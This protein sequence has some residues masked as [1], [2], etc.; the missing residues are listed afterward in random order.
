MASKGW[1]I[2]GKL[3]GVVGALSA[4]ISLVQYFSSSGPELKATC[5]AQEF[6]VPVYLASY[7]TYLEAQ[8][9][10]YKTYGPA[11]DIAK[12]FLTEPTPSTA[13]AARNVLAELQ[14]PERDYSQNGAFA[15]VA[16]IVSCN[17]RN[18]GTKAAK[19]I[20]VSYQFAP[21]ALFV[22]GKPAAVDPGT[23]TASVGVINPKSSIDVIALYVTKIS[24]PPALISFADGTADIELAETVTGFPRKVASVA[25]FLTQAVLIPLLLIGALGIYLLLSVMVDNSKT[26]AKLK[27]QDEATPEAD[28]ST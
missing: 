8:A 25:A 6:D 19:D 10:Q 1:E 26:R 21:A 5:T 7:V 23:K 3:A 16:S 15:K 11:V 28:G 13:K 17:I 22:H 27:A 9:E 12:Q 4:I 2:F 20:D 18:T 24:Y 14:K